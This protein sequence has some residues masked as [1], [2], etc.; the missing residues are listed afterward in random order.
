MGPLMFLQVAS[1]WEAIVTLWA[2]KRLQS[3][4]SPLM[5]LQGTW[6]WRPLSHFVHLNSFSPVWPHLSSSNLILRSSCPTLCTWMASPPC[7][8]SHVPSSGLLLRS[9]CHTL[10][11]FKGFKPVLVLSCSFKGLDLENTC[12]T[13]CTWMASHL[14]GLIC[15]QVTCISTLW[16]SKRLQSCVSPLMLLPGTWSWKT[17]VT[18]CALEW[19]L[20]CVVS[21][22]SK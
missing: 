14:C 9:Y 12:H 13:L 15:L 8:S 10:S 5:L 19:L 4:V 16:A 18:L 6:S 11:I 3:C 21:C 1:C 17:L 2:F 20:S 7:E 22:V